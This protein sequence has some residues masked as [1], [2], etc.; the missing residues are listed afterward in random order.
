MPNLEINDIPSLIDD[1]IRIAREREPAP[2]LGVAYK[3][4]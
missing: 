3:T 4:D 2:A 1:A